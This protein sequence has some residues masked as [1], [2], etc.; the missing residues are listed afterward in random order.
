MTKKEMV[1]LI[2]EKTCHER[3][4]VYIIIQNLMQCIK[5]S[6][7]NGDEVYLRGF[8]TFKRKYRKSRPARNIKEKTTVIVPEC[9][10]PYFTPSDKFKEEVK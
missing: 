5:D 4:T 2:A 6:V 7:K 1:N 9:Y 3:E 10:V 8:G